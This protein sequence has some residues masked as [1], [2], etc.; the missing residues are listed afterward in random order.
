MLNF[1]IWKKIRNQSNICAT[2]FNFHCFF[3]LRCYKWYFTSWSIVNTST[4][5][6]V[7]LL[8]EC[9]KLIKTVSKNGGHQIILTKNIPCSIFY[10]WCKN[11]LLKLILK[12]I[13]LLN[14]YVV[15]TQST[16]NEYTITIS[17]FLLTYALEWL[18]D[19]HGA[20]IH[21]HLRRI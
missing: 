16:R 9:R 14:V 17:Y 5:I 3:K 4:F 6:K 13:R 12:P 20:H 7:S 15:F 18:L 8:S 2:R 10:V 21:I 1:Q 11:R 19:H